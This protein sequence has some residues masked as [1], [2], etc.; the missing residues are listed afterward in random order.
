MSR[1]AHVLENLL[2]VAPERAEASF[3]RTATGIEIDLILKLPGS[4]LWAI[5]IKRTTAPKL[6]RGLRQALDD[7]QPERAFMVYGGKDRYP[8]ADKV[9]AISLYDLAVELAA[10]SREYR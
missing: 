3:Y 9:E 2:R 8:K 6:E 5:E 1:E 10:L 4:R 7:V